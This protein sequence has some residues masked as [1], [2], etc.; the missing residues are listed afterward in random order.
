MGRFRPTPAVSATHT[1]LCRTLHGTT[2]HHLN[3][4]K[5]MKF[6]VTLTE[7]GKKN[8]IIVWHWS[9]GSTWKATIKSDQE[10]IKPTR[11]FFQLNGSMRPTT[12]VKFKPASYTQLA[13]ALS[14]RSAKIYASED[15][16]ARECKLAVQILK[17]AHASAKRNLNTVAHRLWEMHPWELIKESRGLAQIDTKYRSFCS[18]LLNLTILL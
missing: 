15:W 2:G 13:L 16:I 18:Q 8:V 17:C 10:K 3:S 11:S 5:A 1:I 4:V 6:S 7:T 14:V 9:K 12:P